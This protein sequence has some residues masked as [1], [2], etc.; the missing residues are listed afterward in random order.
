MVVSKEQNLPDPLISDDLDLRDFGFMPLEIERLKH[1]RAWLV[2]ARNHPELGFYMINLWT[3]AWHERPVGSLE[4]DDDMLAA[5]AMCRPERWTESVTDSV[6][7]LSVRDSVLHGFIRCADGRLYH[8]VVVEKAL[9]AIEKKSAQRDR[10]Q[11]ARD[12][13]AAKKRQEP[14]GLDSNIPKHRTVTKTV[15]KNVTDSVTDSK[16]REGNRIEGKE[17]SL[18]S[19]SAHAHAQDPF[20]RFWE[21]YPRKVDKQ[22]A[23]Q[24]WKAAIRKTHPDEIIAAVTRSTWSTDQQFIPHP[25]TWL[26]RERW[27]ASES[28]PLN[29]STP[30]QNDR[31]F[32]SKKYPDMPPQASQELLDITEKAWDHFGPGGALGLDQENPTDLQWEQRVDCFRTDGDRGW[33]SPLWGP[34]PDQIGCKAPSHVVAKLMPWLTSNTKT[35]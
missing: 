19:D 21:A 32:R 20:D 26:N 6:A 30:P 2:I 1:S 29:G 27:L 25:S 17:S 11:A 28:L 9:E 3:A 15:T 12:A 8:P 23:K 31:R 5:L 35:S 18:R 14:N 16:G 4:D 24:A 33:I 34:R 7:A 22:R 10:T 13:L